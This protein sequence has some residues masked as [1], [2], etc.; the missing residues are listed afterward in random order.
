M[1]ILTLGSIGK[2][3]FLCIDR[4]NQYLGNALLGRDVVERTGCYNH[5]L[6]IFSD[7][8]VLLRRSNFCTIIC[9]VGRGRF[10]QQSVSSGSYNLL[11]M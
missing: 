7:A 11:L 9:K 1:V 4:G 3:A 10:G 8:A 2:L 5:I 6:H